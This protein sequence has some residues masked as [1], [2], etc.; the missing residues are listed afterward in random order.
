[1]IAKK[2]RLS[3]HDFLLAKKFGKNFS[4]PHFN[5]V[6]FKPTTTNLQPITRLSVVTPAKLAKSAVARNRLR[7][8]IYDL[9]KTNDHRLIADIILYPRPSVLN[10]SR[11]AI[12][13]ELNSF[14]STLHS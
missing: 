5:L 11:A 13:S 7:R 3:R 14:L 4:T 12:A 9:L 10:L 8:T 6:F 2:F 1:M